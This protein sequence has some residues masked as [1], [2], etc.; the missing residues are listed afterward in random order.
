MAVLIC[1][2][3]DV[4]R[5]S[6]D[7]SSLSRAGRSKLART[8]IIATIT[9]IRLTKKIFIRDLIMLKIHFIHPHLIKYINGNSS[10]KRIFE[11]F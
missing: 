8:A 1:F 2:I 11:D 5:A 3:F 7:F 9:R 4:Q 6:L 10:R